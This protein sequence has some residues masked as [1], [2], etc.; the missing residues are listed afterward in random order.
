MQAAEKTQICSWI[1]LFWAQSQRT[2]SFILQ[3]NWLL[4]ALEW[5]WHDG[6]QAP[7]E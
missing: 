7:P 2:Y 1:W 6:G 4:A 3:A 5:H